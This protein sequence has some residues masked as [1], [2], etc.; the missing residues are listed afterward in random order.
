MNRQLREQRDRAARRHDEAL[1]RYPTREGDAF[2]VE[3]Q[4][5]VNELADV[6][7]HA[8][9]LSSDPVEVSKTYRWLGDAYFDLGLAKDEQLLTRGAQAYQRAEELLAGAEAPLEKAKLHFS[10]GNTLRALSAGFNVGLLEAAQTRYESA[11]RTFRSHRLPDLAATVEQQLRSIDPQL[12]LARKMT[13]L[14]G[15]H[16]KLEELQQRLA[17]GGAVER[18]QVAKELAALDQIRK[19]GN[20]AE[21]LSEALEA[22]RE[23]VQEHPERVEDSGAGLS[24][25]AD[26]IRGL[27]GLLEA[28]LSTGPAGAP[29]PGGGAARREVVAAL[30]ERLQGEAAAGKVSPDRA[31][32]LASVLKQFTEAMSGGKDDLQSMAKQAARMRE[33]MQQFTDAAVSP[34]WTTPD[35]P[36]GTPAHRAVSVLDPLKRYLLAE[37]GRGMLPSEEAAAGTDLL[38]RLIKLEARIREA[39]ADEATITSLEGETWRLALAVQEHARRYHLI[40]AAPIFGTAP[41]H[42]EPRSVF[43]S[44]DDVLRQA[45]ER[46]ASREGLRLFDRGGRGDLARERWNQLCSASVAVFDVGV[47]EGAARAQVCYELGLALALGKPLVVAARPRQALPFDVNMAPII[48]IGDAGIDADRVGQGLQQALGSIVWGGGEAGLGKGPDGALAY[49]QHRFVRQLGDGSLR[50]ATDLARGVRDDAVAFRRSLGQLLGMLGAD[51]PAAF[52]PAWPPEYPDPAER[53]RLFHIMPFRPTWAAPTRDLARA[54][55]RKSG[56]TYT[57]GDETSEQRI[58]RGIWV[59]IARS[60]AVLVDI[61]GQNPNVALELGLTH[62]LGRPC[63]VVAQGDP[64]KHMFE[65]LEKIQVHRYGQGSSYRGLAEQVGELVGLGKGT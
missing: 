44:G 41:M 54:E 58:I 63:R 43:V 14:Q 26:Q 50:I 59:E 65:S 45:G 27:Q 12:R 29:E 39:A 42:A 47:A 23:Q 38:A 52:L 2:K 32:Q 17:R 40:V 36:S 10:Y 7:R 13:A 8:D 18:E 5:V 35:P 24:S 4:A 31:T 30:L 51:A 57:R 22:V 48:L 19:Q 62:A 37:K 61:T 25:L 49:L 1:F 33:L 46:L 6:A 21:T 3:L 28:R 20:F 11:A 9:E 34:S 55:C 15:G 53:P 64:A 56:W 16:R 60:S